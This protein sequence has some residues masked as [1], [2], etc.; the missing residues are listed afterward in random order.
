MTENLTNAFSEDIR[1]RID[2]E[3]Y[4]PEGV[5]FA[6]KDIEPGPAYER[7]GVKVSAIEVNHGEKIKPS[8]GYVVEY[9][10]KKPPLSGDTKPD[11]RAEKS[12]ECA[13][14]L[15]PEAPRLDP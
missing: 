12:A 6:A 9:D 10:G 8:F 11:A 7:N 2:D 14:L 1:I 13:E 15:I 3:N 4:P 5:A